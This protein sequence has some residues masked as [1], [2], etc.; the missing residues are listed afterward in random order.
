MGP[1]TLHLLVPINK[2]VYGKRF[3]AGA[4]VKEAVNSWLQIFDFYFFYVGI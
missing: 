3:A 1:I 4:D 2:H